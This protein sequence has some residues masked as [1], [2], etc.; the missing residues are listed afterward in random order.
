[1][2]NEGTNKSVQ[3]KLRLMQTENQKLYAVEIMAL[4]SLVNRNGWQYINLAEHLNEFLD[5]PILTAYLA[6]GAIIGDGHNFNMRRDPATGEEYPSFTAS[7]AERIVGW[8]PKDAG[9]VR[10]ETV[11]DVEWVVV[12]GYLWAWYATELV[13]QI[14][15][16]GDMEVSIET[17]VTKERKENSVDVEEEYLVLGITIL[18]NG[19]A[20]A[21][22]GANI[23]SLAE[24]TELRSNMAENILKAASYIG[25]EKIPENEPKNNSDKGVRDLI[26]LKR[27]ELAD[28][29]AKFPEYTVLAAG[30]DDNGIHVCLMSKD[31]SQ[32][33]YTMESENETIVPEKMRRVNAQA[34]FDFG[35]ECSVNVDLCD[36]T[37]A[38]SANIV[39]LSGDLEK[40]QKDL[41]DANA[42]I[43]SMRNAEN[44]RR[45]MAAKAELDSFNANSAEKVDE[46]ILDAINK[47]IDAG[48]YTN[49]VNAD[50]VWVGD[51]EAV[52]RVQAACAVA[53]KEFNR[54]AAE[55]NNSIFYLDKLNNAKGQGPQGI[56]GLLSRLG[57]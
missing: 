43:E 42:T 24:L 2:E 13:N 15:R 22:A 19:V 54:K 38:L 14:V 29:G 5:I 47:D 25:E 8:I 3:G 20:P 17:L 26:Y 55:K 12:K 7:D 27:K 45:V 10:L 11:D 18:G 36:M 46:A 50:G 9:N 44:A 30:K 57:K 39:N 6:E 1:M 37:D 53:Q 33:A 31:G 21:V 48:L 41:A 16:Q 40:C 28:L 34:S 56:A 49:K 35:E 32:A 51:Q 52:T 23:K 4:N